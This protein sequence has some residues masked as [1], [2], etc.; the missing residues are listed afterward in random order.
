MLNDHG[1]TGPKSLEITKLQDLRFT[2]GSCF[3]AVTKENH[4]LSAPIQVANFALGEW[5]QPDAA[6]RLPVRD[7]AKGAIIA[8]LAATG[9]D[10]VARAMEFANAQSQIWRRVPVTERI[11]YL[12]KVR[13]CCGSVSICPLA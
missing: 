10:D 2:M 1:S 4:A 9:R 11:Q 7:P 3:W 12:F 8:E 5:R 6:E 13:R